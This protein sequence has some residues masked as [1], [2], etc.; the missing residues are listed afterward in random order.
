VHKPQGK[1]PTKASTSD[2]G[3]SD[4]GGS[5]LGSSAKPSGGSGV[6]KESKPAMKK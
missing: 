5:D 3:G 4:L 2:F 1:V 6:T